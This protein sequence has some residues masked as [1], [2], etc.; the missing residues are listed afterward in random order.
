MLLALI[1]LL[2]SIKQLQT[3]TNSGS[4]LLGACYRA[5]DSIGLGPKLTKG[6]ISRTF[7]NN[8]EVGWHLENLSLDLKVRF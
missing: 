2:I 3:Y 5:G 1:D 6:K 8:F 4:W 7:I